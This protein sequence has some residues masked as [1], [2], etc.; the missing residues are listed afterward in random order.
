MKLPIYI[1]DSRFATF[2]EKLGQNGPWHTDRAFQWA[3]QV[4]RLTLIDDDRALLTERALTRLF[5]Y[6]HQLE[7]ARRVIFEMHGRAILAD[8]VGLGK[9]IEAGLILKEYLLRRMV[10]RALILVPSSLVLQWQRELWQ[11]FEIPAMPVK[12]AHTWETYDLLI[13]SLDMAKRAPHR[14]IVLNQSYDLV[15]VDEAHKLKNPKTQNHQ[16]VQALQKKYFLL[17]TATPIQNDIRELYRLV[18]LLRP[19]HLGVPDEFARHYIVGKRTVKNVDRLKTNL[20][21]VL[22]R[23]RREDHL[24]ELPARRVIT[25]PVTLSREEKRFY[26][27]VSRFIEREYTR[28]GM[29][30]QLPLMTLK[31]CLTSSRDAVYRSLLRLYERLPQDAPLAAEIAELARLGQAIQRQSK[32][33]KL[34]ELVQTI[35][36][37]VIVFAEF[38]PTLFS[39][40]KRLAASS[41][42]SVIYRGGYGRNKKD[43]MRELFMNR[44]QVMLATEA[45]GEGIN[46]QFAHHL[47]NYD[48]P[49]NPM[50]LEQ[51]IGRIHRIGQ[52]K[53]VIIYNF[54]TEDTV[55]MAI[56]KLL[57]EKIELF[58]T[59]I[60][61]LD[62]ILERLPH[63]ISLE[64]HLTD[65]FIRSKS[66]QE[67]RLRLG[68]VVD[69]IEALKKEAEAEKRLHTLDSDQ[70]SDEHLIDE[71]P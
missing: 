30:A 71:L 53:E 70:N 68:T 37:K 66:E 57:Y 10:K 14:E 47:V 27:A 58:E 62:A 34:I 39:L 48:L 19:G 4:R 23:N 69:A 52:T 55:E 41:V 12:K 61:R 3:Y 28:R 50:K 40:Q 51:R 59:V 13:A 49:W 26:D 60:G 46:L 16:F 54:A 15:I 67:L 29:S 1:D 5:F 17:L 42:T 35:N 25:I 18:D 8:E 20:G 64:R 2:L 6:P 36:D 44:A 22:I 9:T 32:A 43:W 7:V 33:E 31:R 11:K 38:H 65:L 24:K 63:G 45:G 21:K 56:L